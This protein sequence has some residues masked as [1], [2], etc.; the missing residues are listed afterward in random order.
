MCMY[1][2]VCVCVVRFQERHRCI[3]LT[4]EWL[5]AIRN[6]MRNVKSNISTVYGQ[7]SRSKQLNLI[8][9]TGVAI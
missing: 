8:T 7:V 6:C 9:P 1:V 2:G 4:T 3:I 5:E